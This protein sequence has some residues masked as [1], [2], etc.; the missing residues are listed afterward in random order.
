[1][2]GL[3]AAV[4]DVESV[5]FFGVATVRRRI[6]YDW[7]R[8]PAFLGT[9]VWTE[10]REG[11]LPPDAVERAF[12]RL[13]LTAAN[14]VEK[15]VR[16]VDFDPETY[17]IPASNWYDGPAAGV[18]FRNK[19]GLRARRLRPEVRG[20]GFD[21]GRDESGAVPPQ[22]LVSTFAE[23]GGFRD[24]VEE[25]EANG[26][27]VTVDAVLERAVERIARRNSTEAFAADSAAVSELRSALAPAIRTFLESG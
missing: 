18:A 21:E 5:T 25:L 12:D 22:E 11:F 10:S 23:D 8:L 1:R 6:D 15:E 27:P 3:L 20:D 14:A 7:D 13:G 4:D 2:D 19:T 17:E 9:D 16:A 24:V 26:R